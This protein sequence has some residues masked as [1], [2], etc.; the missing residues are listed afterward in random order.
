MTTIHSMS[1]DSFASNRDEDAAK[2]HDQFEKKK[3]KRKNN[4]CVN[5]L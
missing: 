2:H 4:T 5:V 1:C 3:Q